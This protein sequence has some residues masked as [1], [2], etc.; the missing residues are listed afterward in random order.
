MNRDLYIP[1]KPIG[2]VSA[3]G[4]LWSDIFCFIAAV[5]KDGKTFEYTSGN[6][7]EM[8]GIHKNTYLKAINDMASAGLLEVSRSK[9]QKMTIKIAEGVT[10]E[11]LSCNKNCDSSYHRNCD[12][13]NTKTVTAY[14]KNC[15]STPIYKK[16]KINNKENNACTS[17]REYIEGNTPSVE[18]TLQGA[19]T[20]QWIESYHRVTGCDYIPNFAFFS[21]SASQM[22][23]LLLSMMQKDNATPTQDILK[24]YTDTFI[25]KAWATA[26]A[27]DREHFDLPYIAKNINK[28][29]K[30]INNDQSSN[31]ANTKHKVGGVSSSLIEEVASILA[32]DG[33]HETD[34]QAY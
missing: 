26:D 22:T 15:D 9:H 18:A 4:S 17:V 25:T 28:F 31:Q 3:I 13:A 16:I 33:S 11:S 23:R 5:T 29:L 8:L 30:R 34:G 14:H 12:R 32:S 21:D 7:A 10:I 2:I 6:V 20:E 19:F 27:F 24:S 1:A